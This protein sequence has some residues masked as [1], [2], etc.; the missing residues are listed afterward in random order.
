MKKQITAFCLI[1]TLCLT[2][3]FSSFGED[4]FLRSPL[5]ISEADAIHLAQ[6]YLSEKFELF[7]KLTTADQISI[8]MKNGTEPIWLVEFENRDLFYGKY[9]VELSNDGTMFSLTEPESMLLPGD[10][11][12][13]I[14]TGIPAVLHDYDISMDQAKQKALQVIQE[15][16]N[17]S[18]QD[19]KQ[20]TIGACF[21]Y[22]YRFCNG[23]EPVWFVSF[24]RDDLLDFKVL[25]GYEGSVIDVSLGN[26]GFENT[27]RH[28]LYIEEVIGVNFS[29]F[30]FYEMT[31]FERAEFSKKWNPVLDQYITQYPYYR[32][33]ND[34]LVTVT[35]KTYGIPDAIHISQEEAKHRAQQI[36]VSLG[37]TADSIQNRKLEFYFEITNPDSPRWNIVLGYDLVNS[38]YK[39]YRVVLD[40]I[41]GDVIEA[42]EI[43]ENMN[44]S[45]YRI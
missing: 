44:I 16:Y 25:L 37:A 31:H 5:D 39:G 34:R 38:N 45:D 30:H 33:R 17:K 40:A 43:D 26:M 2:I 18:N 6:S 1:F 9:K 32:T 14:D 21:V 36:V 20:Y 11:S 19:V 15:K 41:T 12:K 10:N 27:K 35:R 3:T 23:W 29:S 13:D 28:G 4:A 24:Y 7:S 22:D 42:F 8:S